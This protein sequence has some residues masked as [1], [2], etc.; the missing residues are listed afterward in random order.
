MA[1]VTLIGLLFCDIPLAEYVTD[2]CSPTMKHLVEHN[3][4]GNGNVERITAPM[5]RNTHGEVA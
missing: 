5:H 1:N 2:S 3:G 4:G